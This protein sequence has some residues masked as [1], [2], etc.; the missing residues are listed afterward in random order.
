ME[1]RVGLRVGLRAEFF[2]GAFLATMRVAAFG[3]R[4][5]LSLERGFLTA[6][7]LIGVR[8]FFGAATFSLRAARTFRTTLAGRVA[9]PEDGRALAT[10]FFTERFAGIGTFL[11]L[12][13]GRA[14]DFLN[15]V[16]LT[17]ADL[18]F[19]RVRGEAS[20]RAGVAFLLFVPGVARF[21]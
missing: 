17:L 11:R 16:F 4:V 3:F 2:C 8:L 20:L 21:M 18:A 19:A 13:A 6:A 10:G 5:V 15:A 1:T 12:A 14:D 9:A 7:V